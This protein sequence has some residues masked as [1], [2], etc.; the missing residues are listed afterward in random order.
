ME[1]GERGYQPDIETIEITEG[2]LGSLY[3]AL[4]NNEAKAI[5]FLAMKPGVVYD[6]A[7]ILTEV[8]RAQG[9]TQKG[10]RMGNEG[11]FHY[12]QKS[13]APVGL[14][15]QE[16]IDSQE[17]SYGYVRTE[18]GNAMGTAFAGKMLQLS[19]NSPDVSLYDLF[20]STVST[21][22]PTDPGEELKKR[23][24]LNRIYLYRALLGSGDQSL[25]MK[26]VAGKMGEEDVT[27]VHRHIKDLARLGIVSLENGRVSISPSAANLLHL[28]VVDFQ[29]FLDLDPATLEEGKMFARSVMQNP[30]M[31]ASF[32]K[33]AREHSPNASQAPMEYTAGEIAAI[34]ESH[35][36][37]TTSEVKDILEELYDKR[38]S[39]HR[40]RK[41][42]Q[43][44]MDQ[45]GLSWPK[46]AKNIKWSFSDN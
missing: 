5:T 22:P 35:P 34:I 40:V 8:R 36:G 42:I 46:G 11:P 38:L 6:D 25:H 2:R 13:F 17:N 44:V 32:M 12:L 31:V 33:K 29:H 37:I 30:D 43:Y 4:G 7:D 24:P 16:V 27:L 21:A 14:V 26:D 39:E 45:R 23:S 10:W 20:G 19:H 15:A 18:W 28:I 41:I 9:N 1:T 3:A